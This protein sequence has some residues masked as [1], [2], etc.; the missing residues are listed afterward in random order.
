MTT[1][2]YDEAILRIDA[3]DRALTKL[4]AEC[5][6]GKRYSTGVGGQSTDACLRNTKINGV[7]AWV[8]EEARSV[9]NGEDW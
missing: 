3:L 9:L 7:S 4:I 1:L 6:S 2:T 8:V 5:D